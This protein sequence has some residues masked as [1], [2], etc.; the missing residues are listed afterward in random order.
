[1]KNITLPKGSTVNMLKSLSFPISLVILGLIALFVYW[2]Y[3]WI[4]TALGLS[5]FQSGM[6]AGA[7]LTVSVIEFLLLPVKA[8][9]A[10]II[11][12]KAQK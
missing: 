8:L 6:L 9:I 4:E 12:K 3:R 7:I 1:M 2:S 5:P 11:S 10:T